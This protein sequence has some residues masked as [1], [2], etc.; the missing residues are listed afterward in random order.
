LVLRSRVVATD[1]APEVGLK[2]GQP[3]ALFRFFATTQRTQLGEPPRDDVTP[4]GQRCIV[5]AMVLRECRRGSIQC[6]L[7]SFTEEP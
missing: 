4:D 7:W 6:R 1:T 2:L 3:A 5:S